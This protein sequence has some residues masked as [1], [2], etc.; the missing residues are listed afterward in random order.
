MVRYPLCPI[1]YSILSITPD[2]NAAC[3]Q[4]MAWQT[5]T[6]VYRAS[7]IINKSYDSFDSWFNL[8]PIEIESI[9][10]RWMEPIL[11]FYDFNQWS[12]DDLVPYA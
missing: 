12:C 4:A 1:E 10:M 9:L 7:I 2:Q 6:I 8:Y 5:K 11:N 3:E